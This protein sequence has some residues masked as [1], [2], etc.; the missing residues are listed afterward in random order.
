MGAWPAG[1]RPDRAAYGGGRACGASA[2]A[3][4]AVYGLIS[5]NAWLARRRSGLRSPLRRPRPTR[6]VRAGRPAIGLPSRWRWLATPAAG[7]GV[8]ATSRRQ[9][10]ATGPSSAVADRR[11]RLANVAVVGAESGR[12]AAR[13]ARARHRARPTP[14]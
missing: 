12:L 10:C 9:P 14:R 13:S 2:S 7:S 1:A 6:L 3:S 4:G 5:A 11:V 8:H